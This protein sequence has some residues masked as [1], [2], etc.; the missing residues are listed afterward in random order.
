MTGAV[1]TSIRECQH[2]GCHQPGKF[3][4][5]K[6]PDNLEEF[7]WFCL[8]HI[9]QYNQKWNFFENHTQSE[10]ETQLEE[11]RV[12]GRSTKPFAEGA[13]KAGTSQP[14]AE[15]KAWQ[16]FGFDDPLE[17]LGENAT[18]NPAAGAK[19]TVRARRLPPT[20][21]KALEILD[22]KDHMTKAEIRKVYKSLVK[23]LHPDMNGGRRD[24]EERLAEVVW[25]WEQI[26]ASRIF[27]D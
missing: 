8:D 27:K 9:R 15:G 22:A 12:W 26:K 17:V 2:D 13:A 1:E 5:P 16:R 11:D 21:R 7:F 10:L 4:A 6:S 25:A 24:D 23:V 20:E 19:E 14:H 3:R 18:L